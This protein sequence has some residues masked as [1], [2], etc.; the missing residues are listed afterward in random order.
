MGDSS[1]I[2]ENGHWKKTQCKNAR[3]KA[4]EWGNG[5]M[6]LR[7]EVTGRS[8]AS[9]LFEQPTKMELADANLARKPVQ[10]SLFVTVSNCLCFNGQSWIASRF[11]HE[12]CH[13]HPRSHSARRW[14]GCG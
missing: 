5:A 1:S 12:R 8:Q 10:S 9:S 3:A 4:C 7:G 13:P 6:D 2:D 14:E 11:I